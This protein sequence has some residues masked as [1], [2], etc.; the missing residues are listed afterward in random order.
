MSMMARFV[1]ITADQLATIQDTPEMVG[2]VFALDAGLPS[3]S[4]SNLQERL[5]RQAPQLIRQ[6][7][8]GSRPSRTGRIR[9][10]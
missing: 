6:A 8:A 3:E 5:R 10:Q 1:A 7:R 9:R 2:G 4:P